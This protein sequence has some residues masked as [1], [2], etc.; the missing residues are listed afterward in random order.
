MSRTP[1]L[2]Q[3]IAGVALGGWV[4]SG[5]LSSYAE[6]PVPAKASGGGRAAAKCPVMGPQELCAK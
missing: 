2:S 4:I 1:R 5:S 6:E 3:V